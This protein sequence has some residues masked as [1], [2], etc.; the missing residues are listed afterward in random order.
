MRLYDHGGN[1]LRS[2][3]TPHA[4][5]SGL[6]FNPADGR[7]AVG[8]HDAIEVLL[9]D[10]ETLAP[11]VSPDI[12]GI[13]NGHLSSVAW[14]A[15]GATLFA[16]GRY[17]E[18]DGYPIFGWDGSGAGP[19][20]ML[21]GGSD[22]VKSL[23]PMPDGALLVATAGPW[24]GVIETDGAPRWTR[25]PKQIAPRGQMS[26]LAVSADGMLV[27]FGP[28]LWG[29][30]ERLRFEVAALKSLPPSEDGRVAPPV[31]GGLAVAGWVDTTA[32]T[33]DGARLS[34]DRLEMARSFAIHPDGGRFIL[35]S[36]WWLRAFDR[37][38]TPL[39]RHPVPGIVSAVNVSGDSRL[40]IAAYGDG[41]L[42][43]HRMEDGAELL[44]LFPL[45]DRENWVAWTPEGIYAATP[46]ARS[47]LRWHVNRGWDRAAEAVPVSEIP[48][49][50]RPEVIR[51]VLPQMGTPGALAVTEMA[52]I[53]GAV[54]RATG[55]DIA[56]GA[57]LHALAI[58]IS[59]YGEAARHL[60]LAY[61]D[62]DARDVA[63]ALRHSQNGLH[64]EVRATS[65]VN[66]EATKTR[67]FAALE[68]MK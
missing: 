43:W 38:G 33:L 28:K 59:D 53:R 42:R 48:E 21:Q 52:K 12:S 65:L 13:G 37:D 9:C 20:R 58:G 23:R 25:A 64:A 62:R 63:A 26:N 39:W 4:R 17:R 16:A 11:Q 29:T 61:A 50:N 36:D 30:E 57:R 34:L 22:T 27:E 10:G 47:I 67:I 24:L 3:A 1:L 41:T 60:D 68:D 19:R 40:A 46:G 35:G 56:P 8:F 31:Q 6:A 18:N 49:T 44:A 14:S 5:P 51:H 32:P 54:R 66:E 2:A 7:L 55:S 15:N 45:P